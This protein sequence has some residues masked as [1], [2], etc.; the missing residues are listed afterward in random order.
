MIKKLSF[1]IFLFALGRVTAQS[2]ISQLNSILTDGPIALSENQTIK[3]LAVMVEFQLDKFDLTQGDGTFGSIYTKDYGNSIIDPLPH[4]V[5]Y[6]SDHLTFAQNYFSKVSNNKVKI[7]FTILPNI[8]TVSKVMRDYSPLKGE[9]FKLL[10][11]FA[12]EVWN[13]ADKNNSGFNFA[14]YNLFVI[15]HAGVGKDISVSDLLGEPRDLPSIYLGLKSLKNFYGDAFNGFELSNGDL[16][17]NSIILPETESREIEGIGGTSLLQ[18]SINGLLVSNLASFLGLP[19]LFDSETGKSAIGRFGLMDG[20]SIFAYSGLFPPEP[21]AWE[22]IFLGW[23]EPILLNSNTSNIKLTASKVAQSG[24]VKIVKVPINSSEYYLIENR[25]RDAEK[26][27]ITLTYKLNGQIRTKTLEKDTDNFNNFSINEF[28]GVVL[29]VDEFDWALPG[30]GILIWHIDENIINQN[31]SENK[32]NVGNNRGVDLEEADGIQDIG[33]EFQTIFGD[34]VIAEGDEFDFWYSSNSSKLFKNKFGIDTKPNTNTNLGA[35]SLITIDN[36]S[37]LSNIM[38]FDLK[39][40][41]E[42]ISFLGSYENNSISEI[43]NIKLINKNDSPL[44]IITSKDNLILLNDSLKIINE[45]EK[46]SNNNFVIAENLP[47]LIVG[48]YQNKINI[49]DNINGEYSIFSLITESNITAPIMMKRIDDTNY[50]FFTAMSNG[51]INIYDYN[52]TEPGNIK[53][54]K[55]YNPTP[56]SISQIAYLNNHLIAI[57][58]NVIIDVINE[59][60]TQLESKIKKAVL[61]LNQNGDLIAVLLGDNNNFIILSNNEL[62]NSFKIKTESAIN[63]FSL[64][65]IKNDGENY[66]LFNLNNEM[67]AKNF[68]GTNAENFPIKINSAIEFKSIIL[69]ADLNEDGF[70]EVISTTSEGLIYAF[71]GQDGNIINGFPLSSGAFA[72]GFNTISKM[73]DNLILS[74]V[75]DDNKFYSWKI[76]SNGK[77]NWNSEYSN[78]YNS[79]SVESASNQ[80]FVSEYLPDNRTYNWPNPVY[81]EE[82]FI[83][84]YVTEDSK[85]NVKIF[86]YS[87]ILIDDFSFNAVGGLDSESIWNVSKVQ[88]G[89]YFA[90]VEAK[91]VTGKSK[92]KIIK[93]AV[94]K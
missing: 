15:F 63:N 65:D 27:G 53:L 17:K 44:Y 49:I 70:S 62:F 81:G 5:N 80:F 76:N 68:A 78:Y 35:N 26:N 14:D 87:G 42:N 52:R 79:S 36:F 47:E 19:D 75:T 73:N 67:Y 3:I 21:S 64:A 32:I 34:I 69:A 91:S 51:A 41:D 39:F 22:K 11:D 83:R 94:I 38:N 66:I 29:D 77:I 61:T 84:T 2:Y 46:F 60:Q 43:D 6:F 37:D 82:T 4:D 45:F 90:H 33:Q 92:S 40:D 54:K 86:D 31:L 55:T 57:S 10:G 28:G 18:L 16:I 13:L 56:S 1:I 59:K 72:K 25:Q 7:D 71:S 48:G 9:S 74:I 85:I 89:G 23:E 93:I 30:N 58:G 50:E 8:I 88:S 20:Q 24:D 12:S